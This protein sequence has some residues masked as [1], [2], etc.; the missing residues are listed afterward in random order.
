MRI[1]S[2]LVLVFTALFILTSCAMPRGAAMVSEVLNE[3]DK[4]SPSFQVVEVT[5][6]ALAGLATWPMTGWNGQ[7]R[8][9]SANRGPSAPVIRNGDSIGL[10]IWDSQENS[11]LTSPA[12]KSVNMAQLVVSPSGTVFVPYLGD[13]VVAGMTPDAARKEIQDQILP[14]APDAQIQIAHT[15]GQE[16]SADLVGGVANPGTYPLAGRDVSIL[17]LIAQGGGIASTLRNPLVRLIR[18]GQTYE[19]RAERLFADA[20]NN[21]LVRGNDKVLVEEDKRYFTALGATGSEKLVYFEKEKITALEA[22]SLIG[23]LSDSRAN[24]KGVLVLRDYDAKQ[25]RPT[26]PTMQQVVFTFDLTSADGLFAA[27]KFQVN[28]MDT[29]L[30]TESPV[31]TVRTITG[32]L[33]SLVGLGTTIGNNS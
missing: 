4:Q 29:V 14:I 15:S 12:E 31:T 28:P 17:S 33:G 16:N 11:L 1:P 8:W 7:Y 10:I 18:A 21:I 3:K 32:L 5:R 25:I 23:G 26:G 6:D 20:S 19:I 22:M 30:A 27:R 13:V 2:K 24:P 9:L